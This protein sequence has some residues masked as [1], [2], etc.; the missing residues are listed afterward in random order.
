MTPQAVQ[1][2]VNPWAGNGRALA[3]ARRLESELAARGHHTRTLVVGGLAEA[4]QWA[5]TCRGD[6]AYLFCIG[7][8][9]TLDATAPA[10]MRLG[11]PLIPVAAGFGNTFARALGHH[12]RRGGWVQILD[13]GELRWVD[14]GIGPDGLFLACRGLGLLE[15]VE[16]AADGAARRTASALRYLTYLR[17]A[18][19][20][21]RNEPLATIQVEVDG[22][23]VAEDA[24]LVI[25]ANV[26]SYHGFLNL[27][28]AATPDDG[29]LDVVVAPRTTKRRLLSLLSAFLLHLPGRQHLVHSRRGKRIWLKA[30]GELPEELG[31]LPRALPVLAP[32]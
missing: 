11:V 26:P 21:L 12:A 2:V 15:Q 31:V 10:A 25:A 19:R 29:L 16:L 7:G 30:E 18:A 5:N 9:S 8:D 27:T 14:A 22:E 32:R 13:D 17:T 4:A 23:R 3:I 20:I 24:A 6:F 28:P 1:L